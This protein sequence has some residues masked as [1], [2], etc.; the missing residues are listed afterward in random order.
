MKRSKSVK[1]VKK[2]AG[3]DPWGA[4]DRKK[5]EAEKPRVPAKKERA[6]ADAAKTSPG[7]RSRAPRP[8]A[9][10][11][12]HARKAGSSAG[13]KAR[14]RAEGKARNPR[15]GKSLALLIF[16]ALV[17]VGLLL[18]GPIM[19]NLDASTE[20]KAKQAEFEKEREKAE[21]LRNRKARANDMGFLEEEAR[22]IGYVLPGEI[23][24]IVVEEKAE[25][26]GPDQAQP[27]TNP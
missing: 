22:R 25:P 5:R 26:S 4:R 17:I 10:T 3:K 21:D 23:P 2:Q 15:R 24:V 14:S 7:N 1:R 20:I 9:S 18:T 13:S 6:R 19:R 12:S 8:E 27:T 16:L 11:N